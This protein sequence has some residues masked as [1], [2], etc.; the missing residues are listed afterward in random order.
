MQFEKVLSH[1]IFYSKKHL[2]V[3]ITRETIKN[4]GLDMRTVII[5]FKEK[6]IIIMI[7]K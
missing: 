2:P 7:I 3:K 1:F 6:I 5:L 4:K